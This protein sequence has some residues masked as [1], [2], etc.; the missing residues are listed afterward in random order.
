M[1]LW[2]TTYE[3]TENENCINIVIIHI[4]NRSQCV[5]LGEDIS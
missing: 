1:Q 2:S 3:L 4:N 5:K